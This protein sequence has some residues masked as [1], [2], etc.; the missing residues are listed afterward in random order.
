MTVADLIQMLEVLPQDLTV[1]VSDGGYCEGA[2]RLTEVQFVNAW[3]SGLDGDEVNDEYIYNEGQDADTMIEEGY[4]LVENEI[5]TKPIVLLK[6][7]L[8][9]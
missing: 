1:W 9:S 3:D 2:A 7:T 4:T 6:S 5:W 8:D